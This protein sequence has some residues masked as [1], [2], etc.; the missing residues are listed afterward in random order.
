MIEEERKK[1]RKGVRIVT[2]VESISRPSEVS[3]KKGDKYCVSLQLYLSQ[4]ADII[5][6]TM[7]WRVAVV[8]V[9]IIAVTE[10]VQG[11]PQIQTEDGQ[12]IT[13]KIGETAAMTCVVNNLG[14]SKLNWEFSKQSLLIFHG[15]VKQTQDPKYSQEHTPDST[16]YTLFINNIDVADEGVYKCEVNGTNEAATFQLNITDSMVPGDGQ[17]IP[18]GP[19]NRTE[20]CRQR[21]VSDACLPVCAPASMGSI[22]LATCANDLPHFIYCGT[23]GRNH[24]NCCARSGLPSQC[25]DLCSGD[26]M[27]LPTA[28]S[29]ASACLTTTYIQTIVSCYQYGGALIPSPPEFV[30]VLPS[31]KNGQSRLL[32]N[33]KKPTYNPSAVLGYLVFYK[34]S[35]DFKFQATK[36]LEPSL[37]HYTLGGQLG[38]TYSIYLVAVGHHGSS[39]PS[40]TVDVT[41]IDTSTNAGSLNVDICCGEHGVSDWCKSALC[42]SKMW[43]TFDTNAMLTCYGSLTDVFTCLAGR[44]DHS[45]CCS[46]HHVPEECMPLCSGHPPPFNSSLAICVPRLPVIVTCVQI[47]LDTQPEAPDGFGL[48]SVTAHAA[49]VKWAD[50]VANGGK[51]VDA[52]YIQ[53][54]R[55]YQ[56]TSWSTEMETTGTLADLVNL[57]ESEN[58]AVRVIARVGN[59]SSLPSVAI[60]F[61]TL[62]ETTPPYRPTV[63]HNLTKCCEDRG[64]PEICSRGCEYKPNMT[65]YYRPYLMYCKDHIGSVLTCAADG[66]D[67]TPCCRQSGVSE[68]CLGMCVL[69]SPGPVNPVFLRCINDTAKVVTC[70]EEGI[71]DL[72]RM[73]DDVAA[74]NITSHT[75]TLQWKN[76]ATG[77]RP[78]KYVVRYTA[79][80]LT[81][82]KTTT[83]LLVVLQNLKPSTKYS[84]TV[85]SLLNGSSSPPT[86]E[87]TEFTP[88]FDYESPS[89]PIL[90]TNVSRALWNNRTHCCLNNGIRKECQPLCLNQPSTVADCGTENLKIL[91]CA[92]DGRDH[93]T[94]CRQEG[95]VES[96][97]SLCS[98]Y[99]NTSSFSVRQAGCLG[100][101]SLTIITSCF[102]SNT[103][104]LPTNPREFIVTNGDS[105]VTLQWQ[106][107]LNCGSGCSYDVHYWRTN[108]ADP[109]DYI[110]EWGVSSPHTVSGLPIGA[111]YTFTVT[112][113]VINGSGPAAP[114]QTLYFGIM[115]PDIS[116][117]QRPAAANYIFNQGAGVTLICQVLNFQHSLT[118]TWYYRG[119]AL[120]TKDRII[121]LEN[122]DR[123]TEG[124]YTCTASIEE[125]TLSATSFLNVRYR[126]EFSH[127]QVDSARPNVGAQAVLEFWFKGFPRVDDLSKVWTKNGNPVQQTSRYSLSSQTRLDIGMTSVKL[128]IDNVVG[129]DYGSYKCHVTNLYGSATA[130]T[131]LMN[132]DNIPTP[133]PPTPEQRKNMTECCTAKKV[134][135]I[136]MPICRLDVSVEEAVAKPEKYGVCLLH[137]DDLINC[138][139]A[140]ADHSLCCDKENVHA[141]CLS[142]CKGQVPHTGNI[143][144]APHLLKCVPESNK[145]LNCMETGYNKIPTAPLNV[146]A[147]VSGTTISVTWTAPQRNADK[148]TSYTLYYNYTGHAQYE[149]ETITTEAGLSHQLKNLMNGRTYNIW[150]TA[151]TQ[152]VGRSQPS[153]LVSVTTEEAEKKDE[154]SAG[155]IVG[156][157][158]GVLAFVA[159]IALIVYFVRRNG[160]NKQKLMESVSFENSGYDNAVQIG[161][162]YNKF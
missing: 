112:A 81:L 136:C 16:V 26:P 4:A 128:K 134:F 127:H 46:T 105:E 80:S 53:L 84:I 98:G 123:K 17:Y 69:N 133:I 71:V 121:L 100:E 5:A 49:T 22:N 111:K 2:S 6:V 150:M 15:L 52:Y 119:R 129:S 78:E 12:V 50:P 122:V 114:W 130:I 76:P 55:G 106:E 115:R 29:I 151:D 42:T 142:F 31:V 63:E 21:G 30:T 36:R 120:G 88:A 32:I 95:L 10:Q 59:L 155:A 23:D 8:V 82:Q 116:I 103:G 159:I 11:T 143:I 156:I 3:R 68:I 149:K 91:A 20:C 124:N 85:T 96:C 62:P 87:I 65:A 13:R 41:A 90:P 9:L 48:D 43:D 101:T 45:T 109:N 99:T 125:F 77:P 66:R 94:C 44:R 162:N 147:V 158:I 27:N 145:I 154:L 132:P 86:N 51:A 40:E 47:G 161:P 60:R 39:Q 144:N 1:K 7:D 58:Y 118:Y 160:A 113:R 141:D 37:L 102:L 19:L 93:S 139:A 126:P 34:K 146:K 64:M 137:F 79:N 35:S 107:A 56:E 152:L 24:E 75:I 38:V 74:S 117:V 72:V 104:L 73:P 92:T 83:D 157:V 108:T 28:A 18:E 89:F 54:Q 138:A 57:T 131:L 153:A 14:T 70:F 97:V 140:G 25:L 61:R 67:H 135:E 148:V 33:W 110:T